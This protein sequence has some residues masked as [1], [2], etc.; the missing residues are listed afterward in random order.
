MIWGAGRNATKASASSGL[1]SDSNKMVLTLRS[2][3]NR[4]LLELRK[5]RDCFRDGPE[6]HETLK[7]HTGSARS[8]CRFIVGDDVK[9]RQEKSMLRV[10]DADGKECT[11][12]IVRQERVS[13]SAPRP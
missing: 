13:G 8:H 5:K 2:K 3:L 1:C 10:V 11:G 6:S 4:I 7:V 9:Y 12:E